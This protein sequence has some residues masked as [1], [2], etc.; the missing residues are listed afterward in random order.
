MAF[1]LSFHQGWRKHESLSI[2]LIVRS[3]WAESGTVADWRFFLVV[4]V[5]SITFPV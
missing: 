2:A 1:A 5:A 4:P 3:S